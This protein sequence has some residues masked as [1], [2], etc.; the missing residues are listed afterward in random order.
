LADEYIQTSLKYQD[1]IREI[2]KIIND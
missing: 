2:K 1:K